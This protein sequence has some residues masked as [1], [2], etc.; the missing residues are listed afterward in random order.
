MG[1]YKIT[2][3]TNSLGKRDNKY[4]SVVD[5]KY[6]SG[7]ERKTISLLAGNT[8]FIELYT[9]PIELQRARLNG[10]II[11]EEV[12]NLEFNNQRIGNVVKP[13]SVEPLVVESQVVDIP[14]VIEE[15]VKENKRVRK[16]EE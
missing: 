8:L 12:S 1:K 15:L 13:L 6:I 7:V 2:N 10:Y 4:N 16:N 3:I 14:E 5:V 11:I 9:I